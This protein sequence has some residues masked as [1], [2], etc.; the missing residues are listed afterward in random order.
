MNLV[1]REIQK[2][3][4]EVFKRFFTENYKNLV[5]YANNYLFDQQ[6]SQDIVQE[7]FIQLW[8]KSERININTSLQAYIRIMVRNR[9]LS[10]LKSIKIV[11]N[12]GMLEANINLITDHNIDSAEKEDKKIIYH[13]ILKIIDSLPEKMQQIVKLKLLEDYTYKEI[14]E[15]LDISVNTVKTQLRRAK[16]KIT[17][18]ITALLILLKII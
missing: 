12:F 16:S 1:I 18:L 3:N 6:A 4:Q 5:L 13:Q 9:C 17:Q 15:E 14:A 10:Y 2:G 11:D 8:E 7:I